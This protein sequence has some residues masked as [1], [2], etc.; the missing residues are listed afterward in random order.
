MVH[1]H[2]AVVNWSCC[3]TGR[4]AAIMGVQMCSVRS[5]CFTVIGCSR[6]LSGKHFRKQSAFIVGSTVVCFAL[7]ELC[8]GVSQSNAEVDAGC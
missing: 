4:H 3:M 1:A 7:H 5:V 6:A 8:S 2:V